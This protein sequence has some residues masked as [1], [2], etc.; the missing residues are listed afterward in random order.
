MLGKVYQ[1]CR[2][3]RHEALGVPD[4]TWNLSLE[5]RAFTVRSSPEAAPEKLLGL[6]FTPHVDGTKTVVGSDFVFHL[7][8]GAEAPK[9]GLGAHVD[10]DEADA[11]LHWGQVQV[12]G[13]DDLD[14][15][16][17]HELVIEH[18]VRQQQLSTATLVVAEIHAG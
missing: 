7:A 13:A 1:Y 17:V 10:A 2:A 5:E 11:V 3:N 4:V 18:V 9:Q 16:D 12:G 15:V 14:A 6:R 8:G